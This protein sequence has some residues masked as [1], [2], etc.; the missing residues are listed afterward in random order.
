MIPARSLASRRQQVRTYAQAQ[1]GQGGKRISQNDFTG[2][3]QSS[4]GVALVQMPFA[5][6]C[7]LCVGLLP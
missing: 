4:G 2:G 1:P 5:A 7:V 6:C 3:P